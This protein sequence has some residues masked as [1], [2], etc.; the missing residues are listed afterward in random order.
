[1]RSWVASSDKGVYQGLQP[2]ILTYF[3][4]LNMVLERLRKIASREDT[5]ELKVGAKELLGV[6]EEDRFQHA[7]A[8]VKNEGSAASSDASGASL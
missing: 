4:D 1:M 5:P 7:A 2:E 6:V 3:F 8:R